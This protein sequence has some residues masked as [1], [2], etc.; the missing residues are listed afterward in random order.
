M[1]SRQFA[2]SVSEKDQTSLAS[3]PF[4]DMTRTRSGFVVFLDRDLVPYLNSN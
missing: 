3:L 4:S 2:K 1:Q